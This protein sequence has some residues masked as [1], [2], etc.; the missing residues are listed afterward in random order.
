MAKANR[1]LANFDVRI[2]KIE[3][4]PENRATKVVMESSMRDALSGRN[5]RVTIVFSDVAAIDFRINYFDNAIGSEAAGLYQIVEQQFAEN[6]VKEIFERRRALYLLEGDYDYH[7][8]DP[9]DLL[10]TLDVYGSFMPMAD[11]YGVFIQNVDA[12]G[13]LVVAKEIQITG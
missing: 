13:Y 10:N 8:D 12:G 3:I 5:R 4:L 9:G 7:A 1:I 11:H 2:S 6:L